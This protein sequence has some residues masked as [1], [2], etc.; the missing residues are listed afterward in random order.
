MPRKAQGT[1]EYLV[2]IAIVVV[3]GLVVVGMLVGIMDSESV[4]NTT[5]KIS[6]KTGQISLLET[7]Q[8]VDGNVYLEIKSN[9]AD[10]ITITNVKVNDTN[11]EFGGNN[12]LVLGSEKVFTIPSVSCNEGEKITQT[13]TITYTT[14]HGLEKKETIEITSVCENA[15]INE[16]TSQAIA[17]E[18]NIAIIFSS[19]MPEDDLTITSLDSNVDF[20]FIVTGNNPIQ[21]SFYLENNLIDSNTSITSGT[22]VY[23]DAN[24]G[25]EGDKNWFVFCEDNTGDTNN[26]DKNIN[27]NAPIVSASECSD[28]E[29]GVHLLEDQNVYCDSSNRMWSATITNATYK[30]DYYIGEIGEHLDDGNCLTH[31]PN[32]DFPVC[33]ACYNL[34]YAGHADWRIPNCYSASNPECELEEFYDSSGWGGNGG[35]NASWDANKLSPD[36]HYWSANLDPRNRINA[37]YYN[38]RDSGIG[39]HGYARDYSIR[40]VR[41]AS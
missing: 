1:I 12:K 29:E 31:L 9:S 15:S 35:P 13:I 27:Y 7:S 11:Q 24:L 8:N 10:P 26:I 37:I 5:N 17:E 4:V 30:P 41:D 16:N 40:C 38:L 21:C 28:L 39:V 22:R 33:M 25:S 23:F 2:I 20:N 19:I 36:P 18:E 32:D 3:I 6:G 14:K 34:E